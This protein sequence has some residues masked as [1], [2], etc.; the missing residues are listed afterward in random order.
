ML[1]VI[2][3]FMA[4]HN[5]PDVTTV[6]DA[7]MVSDTNRRDIRQHAGDRIPD[8]H[9]VTLRWPALEGDGRR[10]QVIYC[11]YKADRARRTPRGIDEQVRKAEQVVAGNPR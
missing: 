2:E 11:Q 7:G 9:I 3:S 8:G 1:P 10:D 6:A 5:L 4:A